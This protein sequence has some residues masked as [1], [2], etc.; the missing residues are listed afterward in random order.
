MDEHDVL[1]GGLENGWQFRDLFQ[2]RIRTSEEV[3][4]LYWA[5]LAWASQYD[6]VSFDDD[7]N[8]HS[9]ND[10]ACF[11][12]RFLFIMCRIP[13]YGVPFQGA[14]PI[15]NAAVHLWKYLRENMHLRNICLCDSYYSIIMLIVFRKLTGRMTD[16]GVRA[17]PQLTRFL[18][19]RVPFIAQLRRSIS[20]CT[21]RTS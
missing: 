8:C 14:R 17:A 18:R 16:T 1:W 11:S 3:L 7:F 5:L 2:P 21:D 4:A 15:P 9:E 10:V 20:L 19:N 12:S 6:A 13:G